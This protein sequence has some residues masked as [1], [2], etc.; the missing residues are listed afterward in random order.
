MDTIWQNILNRNEKDWSSLRTR[1]LKYLIHRQEEEEKNVS[2]DIA[3][4]A[5]LMLDTLVKNRVADEHHFTTIMRGGRK[6]SLANFARY[7]SYF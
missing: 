3:D 4:R 6:V 2:G 7:Y 1:K 5:M